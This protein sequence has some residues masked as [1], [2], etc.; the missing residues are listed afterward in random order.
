M[1]FSPLLAVQALY[2]VAVLLVLNFYATD[3]LQLNTDS[4]EH[5]FNVKNTVIFNAFVLCQVILITKKFIQNLCASSLFF[6]SFLCLLVW[7]KLS[8]LAMQIFN[9]FNARKPDEMNVFSGVTKNY[10]FMGIVGT[11]FLLQVTF[12]AIFFVFVAMPLL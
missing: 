8:N 9:E 1:F 4:K 10:L 7:F 11:T 3:I 2:Q 5:A 6:I 12:K